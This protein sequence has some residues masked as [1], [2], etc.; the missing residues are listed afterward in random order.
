MMAR[1]APVGRLPLGVLRRAAGHVPF[2]NNASV[3]AR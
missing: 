3:A 2:G 1:R